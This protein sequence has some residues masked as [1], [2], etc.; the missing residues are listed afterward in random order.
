MNTDNRTTVPDPVTAD[1][2]EQFSPCPEELLRF[3]KEFPLGV[4]HTRAHITKAA[5][6]GF[7]LDWFGQ[8]CLPAP[9]WEAYEKATATAREAYNK[10]KATAWEA[11]NKATATALY[12]ALK[13]SRRE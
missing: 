9:A 12:N 8:H 6:L 4:R 13:L 7:N 2:L 5:L 10:A 11:Y 3:R 1:W